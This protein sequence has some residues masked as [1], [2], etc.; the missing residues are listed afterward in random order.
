MRLSQYRPDLVTVLPPMVFF[1][2]GTSAEEID[3]LF[4]SSA[5]IEFWGMLMRTIF[6]GR[7][8]GSVIWKG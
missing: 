4:N 3:L 7:S 5:A 1:W 2:P 8:A 6:G